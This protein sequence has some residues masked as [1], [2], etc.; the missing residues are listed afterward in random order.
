MN[1]I[2]WEE[3]ANLGHSRP[4]R[5]LRLCSGQAKRQA[6]AAEE[7]PTFKYAGK[8]TSRHSNVHVCGFSYTGALGIPHFV[9]TKGTK[10]RRKKQYVPNPYKLP[11]PKKITSVACGYGFTLLSSNSLESPKVWGTG[12]NTDSQLGF[13]SRSHTLESGLS[14]VI[15]PA[16]LDLPLTK[17]RDTRV[18]QVACGRAH[19]IILTDKEGVFSLGN[20]AHGQC[21]RPVVDQEDYSSSKV[22]TKIKGIEGE[23]KQVACGHDHSLFLTKAGEVYSCGWGADGQTGLGHYDTCSTP[24]KVEGDLKGEAIS[25][26]V[27]FS[28][29][30]L[31][32]SENGDLFGW[33]N[34]EYNQ[35][36]LVSEETQVCT[37]R[38]LKCQ[39]VG[40]NHSAAVGGSICAIVNNEGDLFTWGYGILGKGPN[41][42]E[43][44]YPQ[45]I[46]STLVGRS[47]IN[48]EVKVSKVR[49][50]LHHFAA[51]T[52]RGDLYTWGTNGTG[53]LG[54]G[55]LG[56]QFFP[57]RVYVPGEV[58]DVACG[59][60]H[61]V[62][63]SKSI[64]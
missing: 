13:Q 64:V 29:C 1:R 40:K 27:A 22:I 35:L 51:L 45:H 15:A 14:Y 43:S 5:N 9:V 56:N 33:G 46:P 18:T 32:V 41:L 54:L 44:K 48:P 26:V 4:P 37:P 60:D 3:T 59:V 38:H 47:N 6:A 34:S 20:N 53:C 12:I 39:G 50:G 62:I 58:L 57:L 8:T 7:L 52:D 24:T 2:A 23:V 36:S 31:A 28:D 63:L 10:Y 30:C 16:R 55:N 49:C 25:E 42:A 11:M 17:P 19:S 61:T 21:G